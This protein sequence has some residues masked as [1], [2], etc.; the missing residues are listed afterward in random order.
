MAAV[1]SG[2]GHLGVSF[3][4]LRPRIALDILCHFDLSFPFIRTPCHSTGDRFWY[5]V[6][7]FVPLY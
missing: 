3:S 1:V 5:F 2:S 7:R 6:C 4:R